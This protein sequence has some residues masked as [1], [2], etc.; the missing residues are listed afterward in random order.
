V[1]VP[2]TLLLRE[3]ATTP[4]VELTTTE[5]RVLKEADAGLKVV[6]GSRPGLYDVEA[7]Q[8][9][10]TIVGPGLHALIQPKV[11]IRRLVHLL[12]YLPGGPHIGENVALGVEDDLLE[13]MQILFLHALEGALAGGLLRD[14]RGERDLLAVPRGRIDGMHLVTKRFG[15]LPPIQCD[16]QEYTPD[17]EVNRRLAA[18]TRVLSRVR[19][20]NHPAT[21][22]LRTLLE[23]F[24]GVTLVDYRRGDLQP[25]RLDRRA[26]R[27]GSAPAL[28]DV[29]L[30]RA[31]IELRQGHTDAVG[32]LL[33][34]DELYER[35]VV[36]GLRD[37]MGLDNYQ[38]VHHLTGLSLD[39][40]GRVEVTPDAVWRDP[41]GRP[42][43][44]L[45][46]KYKET[47][48]GVTGDI[49]Q[50]LAYCTAVGVRTGVLVYAHATETTHV[51]RHADVEV[52]VLELDPDG[53]PAALAARLR[54]VASQIAHLARLKAD[55]SEHG[56]VVA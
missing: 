3:R 5:L 37:A 55:Q 35:F 7:S 6:A 10:G 24:E 45:D 14:Y 16:Y 30:A 36:S 56:T 32:F 42:L 53:D 41:R 22:R 44:V 49:Y 18:A 26:F 19:S 2:R 34:M 12:R 25:L 29:V 1:Q 33:N 20:A 38:W 15:V 27:Y 4:S 28:A 9:V 48:S 43:L 17:I 8:F 51:V 47:G 31:S 52:H 13:V 23:R 40:A 50:A 54:Q 46:A 39:V 11:P 21:A